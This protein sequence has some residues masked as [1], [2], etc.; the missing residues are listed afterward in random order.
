MD[1]AMCRDVPDQ[2]KCTDIERVG[3]NHKE[4]GPGASFRPNNRTMEP[5]IARPNRTS[6]CVRV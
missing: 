3:L 6:S 5:R 2:P 4:T 1:R